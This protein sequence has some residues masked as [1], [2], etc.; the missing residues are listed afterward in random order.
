M[1]LRDTILA[2]HSKSQTNAII[3]WVGKSQ[4]RFNEL[5][6]LFLNDEYRVVQR[7]AWPVSYCVIQHPPLIKKHF[8]LLLSNLKKPDIHNPVKRNTVRFLQV[9]E[10]PKKY[11]GAV[12][13]LCFSYIA[14]PTEAVAVKAFSLTILQK[15]SK[16]YP[17]I[18]PEIKLII[19]ERWE[20]ETAAFRVRAKKILIESKVH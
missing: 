1:N 4:Q 9:I 15:L 8:E 7:A 11:Q 6:R 2:E 3:R 18:I 5:F 16:D 17:G 10:I 14:S 19:E 13:D 20:H 12:M